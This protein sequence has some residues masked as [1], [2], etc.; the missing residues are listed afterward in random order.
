[1]DTPISSLPG[2]ARNL[3]T[4]AAERSIPCTRLPRRVSGSAIRPVPMP[5]SERLAVGG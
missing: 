4:I 5:S 2:F 1:M 3:A